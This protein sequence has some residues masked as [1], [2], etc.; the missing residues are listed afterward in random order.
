MSCKL[1]P[2]I[3]PRE[4]SQR[5]PCFDRCQ[6]IAALMSN[7][8]EVHSKP[9]LYVFA[10]LFCSMAAILRESIVAVV[11]RTRPRVIPLL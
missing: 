3:W 7:I 2:A 11:V 10:N 1:K 4:T 5:I 6:L 9:S 8:K